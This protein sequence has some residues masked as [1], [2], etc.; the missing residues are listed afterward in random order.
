MST[1][2]RIALRWLVLG[3]LVL[4]VALQLKL[5]TG[6]GGMPEVWRLR[7]RVSAQD[8]ENGQLRRRNEDLGADVA[9]LKEGREGV[10]ERARSELGMVK[11]GEVFYQVVEPGPGAA[12]PAPAA[13][14]APPER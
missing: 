2:T 10:E 1:S 14:A 11:P 6:T 9:D 13:E 8:E 5:W 7:E 12:A 4:I 3:L